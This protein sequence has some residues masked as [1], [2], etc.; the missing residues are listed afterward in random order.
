MI[1]DAINF[2]QISFLVPANQ[3][4]AVFNNVKYKRRIHYIIII[5]YIIIL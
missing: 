5:Y 3:H 1:R 2:K 4:D